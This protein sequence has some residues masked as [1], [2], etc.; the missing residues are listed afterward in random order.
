MRVAAVHRHVA[1]VAALAV[2][3]VLAVSGGSGDAARSTQPQIKIP[4]RHWPKAPRRHRITSRAPR[5]TPTLSVNVRGGLTDIGNT[6]VTC[7]NNAAAR[8]RGG[9]PGTRAGEPCL[10]QN[11]NDLNMRDRKSVV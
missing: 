4:P 2:G 5:A 11:N 1:V 7:P 8:R 10:G 6:L 9:R 3:G